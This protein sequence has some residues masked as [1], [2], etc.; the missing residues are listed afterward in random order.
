MLDDFQ[1]GIIRPGPMHQL[2]DMYKK[3]PVKTII[4]QVPGSNILII[5]QQTYPPEVEPIINQ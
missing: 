5:Q 2:A 4:T 1:W 3:Y